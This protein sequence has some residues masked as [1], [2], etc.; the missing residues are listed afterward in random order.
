M[1]HVANPNTLLERLGQ[2]IWN[3]AIS[4]VLTVTCIYVPHLI[5]LGAGEPDAFARMWFGFPGLVPAALILSEISA[6]MMSVFSAIIVAIF[7]CV[8]AVGHR[9]LLGSAMLAFLGS[10]INAGFVYRMFLAG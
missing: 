10:L 1:S 8:G 6:W 3:W 7:T 5:V 4:F 2:P 9:A